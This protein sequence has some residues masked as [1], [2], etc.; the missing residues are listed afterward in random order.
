MLVVTIRRD[1][2]F[3]TMAVKNDIEASKVLIIN[4]Y[5]HFCKRKRNN[6]K[7]SLIS[8]RQWL[9]RN[10]NIIFGIIWGENDYRLII[11]Y[12]FSGMHK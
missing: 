7:N 2:Y 4:E 9:F 10:R 6:Q 8:Y 1:G 12:Y 11:I 3:M 5:Y